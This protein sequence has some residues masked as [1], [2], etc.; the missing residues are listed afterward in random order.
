MNI[1]TRPRWALALPASLLMVLVLLAAQALTERPWS[2]LLEPPPKTFRQSGAFQ[3]LSLWSQQRA[4]PAAALP[5]LGWTQAAAEVQRL[6][7]A[8]KAASTDPWVAM[9]PLNVP[10]RMLAVTF[11]P[12]NPRTLYAGSASGGLWRTHTAGE[13]LFAWERV[14]TGH[15]VLGVGAVAMAPDDT[16]TLYIGTGEVYNVAET[17]GG[18]AVRETRGS[19]GLGILKSEDGGQTWRRSLDRSREQGHGVQMLRFNPQ[20]TQTVWA[21][22]TEGVLVTRDAGASWQVALNVA[23]ATD[24]WISPRDTSVVMAAVGNLGST[25]QGVYRSTDGGTTWTLLEAL[26]T[27]TFGKTLLSGT[28]AAPDVVYASVGQG[29]GAVGGEGTRLYRSADAG[30]TWTLMNDVD[31]AIYQGWFA[32]FAAPRLD[33]P[34]RLILGGVD[35]WQ[36]WAKG[37]VMERVSDWRA[38]S[39]DPPLGGP[40]GA[41]NY[42]HADH[43]GY[44][45]HPTDPDVTYFATDGGISRTLDG[46]QTFQI[47]SGGLQTA[48]FYNGVSNSPIDSMMVFGGLQDN[49]TVRNRRLGRWQMNIGGDGGYTAVHPTNRSIYYGS[50]QRLR[51]FRTVDRGDSW[52]TISPPS[53]ATVSFVA[54]YVLAPSQPNTL[55]AAAD[56]VYRSLSQ[57]DA[58]TA[59]NG[60]QPLDGNPVLAL[61]VA[62]QNADVVYATTAPTRTQAGVFVT[63]DGGARWEAITQDLPNRY[64]T[65]LAVHP[66]DPGIAYVTVSGFG[67][68]HLFRTS[69]YGGTWADVS[70][71]LPD[72]PTSAVL[73]HPTSPDTVFVGNDLGVFRSTDRGDTW[74]PFSEGLP[75]AVMVSDL[76]YSPM[77]DVLRVATHGNGMYQRSLS[78]PTSVLEPPPPP[79]LPTES[80]L[81]APYPNP[82]SDRITLPLELTERQYVYLAVYDVRGRRVQVP[83]QGYR[84]A[85]LHEIEVALEAL[86]AGVYLY[87]IESEQVNRTGTFTVVR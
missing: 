66:D 52:Q 40:H 15:P 43:H 18:V 34:D 12:Q 3:A 78:P 11:N 36:G 80:Q 56:V 83:V 64:L 51:I 5:S 20:N 74:R 9:G 47:V 75:E 72:L 50:V 31:Y 21:A 29:S 2:R 10:G 48:Q 8:G 42:S 19:Y 25:G 24:L 27:T 37:Q 63:R 17:R 32:H 71:G 61:A 46:G 45:H 16:L 38:W 77:N 23:M 4:Y 76:V 7:A 70:D 13:G 55:Y 60:G 85:G 58:W 39:F 49:S 35:L 65:D 44:A 87:A 84:A 53:R 33:D 22:T 30:A 59:T 26:P 69:D 82:A 1:E 54:P 73:I 57:G 62:P 67:T 6:E 41:P 28:P 81:G 86:P 79:P 68:S 14:A